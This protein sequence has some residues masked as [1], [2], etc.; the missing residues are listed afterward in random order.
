MMFVTHSPCAA[1]AE[2]IINS[3]V[4]HV[5]FRQQYRSPEGL[6]L[7]TEAGISLRVMTDDGQLIPM[8]AH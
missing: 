2:A 4:R 3:K 6:A 7:L 8:W 1:C 5:V